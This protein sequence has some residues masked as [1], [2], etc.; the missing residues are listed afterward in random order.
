MSAIQF[1]PTHDQ[2]VALRRAAEEHDAFEKSCIVNAD[3]KDGAQFLPYMQADAARSLK[4]GS[5]T[6]IAAPCEFRIGE[7]ADIK[8][9]APGRVYRYEGED[10]PLCN[11]HM[12]KFA[13]N[14]ACTSFWQGRLEKKALG[15]ATCTPEKSLRQNQEIKENLMQIRTEW[16]YSN[17]RVRGF[18]EPHSGPSGTDTSDFIPKMRIYDKAIQNRIVPLDKDIATCVSITAEQKGNKPRYAG[19]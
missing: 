19:R 15:S 12:D 8:C 9:N 6:G 3:G 18:P 17:D 2:M 4:N 16:K 5:D 13:S 14:L 1:G 10:F 7:S 11:R